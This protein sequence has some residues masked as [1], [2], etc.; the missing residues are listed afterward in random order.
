MK[1]FQVVVKLIIITVRFGCCMH[2]LLR[3]SL[4]RK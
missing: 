1:T 3:V 4:W 2:I